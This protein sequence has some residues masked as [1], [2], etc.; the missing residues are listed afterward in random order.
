MKPRT[1]YEYITSFPEKQQHKLEELRKI[2]T[3]VLPNTI[4]G[5]KWGNPA[6]IDQDGM[7]LVIFSG[8][9]S[10]INLVVTPS[11]KKAFYSDLSDYE[12]GKGSIKLSYEQPFP[13]ELI[14]KIVLYRAQEYQNDGIKWM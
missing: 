9:K 3:S 11:T 6:I 7:I 12:T 2:I 5:I 8:H 14:K 4:E 13:A 10:H 1:V